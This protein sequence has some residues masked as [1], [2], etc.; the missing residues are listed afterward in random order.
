MRAPIFTIPATGPVAHAPSLSAA[1]SRSAT[2]LTWTAWGV[3]AAL[4]LGFLAQP[5]G[6]KA[7]LALCG[8][9][10]AGMLALWLFC[11]R[12]GLARM[13]F[14]A[15]GTLVVIRYVYWRL[16]TTLPGIDDPVSFGLGLVLLAAELYCVLILTVSLIINVA[17]LVR[18]AAPVQDDAD[19]PTVD[20][21]V[22]SYNEGTEILAVTLA[23]ARNLD[24]PQGRA[25][26]W[27]LDDGGTDQKCA[28]ADPA[29]AAAARARR[30][31][32]Q[33]LCADL[34]IR[35]LTRARNEHAKAGNLNGG[36]TQANADIVL[37]LDADH[38]P[39]RAF[40]RE[41]VGLFSADPKL[42]L[43]Q[44]P[45]VFLNPDPIE[46]NLRTFQAMPPRTRCSTG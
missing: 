25:T 45:H 20:I 7:Q 4:A 34:G 10:M 31:E 41:T 16:T 2:A 12:R 38:A 17:P 27:L 6:A 39:F 11:P 9:A 29:K 3:S 24:Y 28:D 33:A 36:L 30:V 32:L 22:P 13:A 5:V 44:T 19:L 40:L 1:R 46:R 23:A 42:F 26:V 8:T 21:F 43:V 14:L 18:A 15:L 37:V 35:Y